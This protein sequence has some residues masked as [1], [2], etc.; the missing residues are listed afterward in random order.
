MITEIFKVWTSIPFSL[1]EDTVKAICDKVSADY[2]GL[3]ISICPDMDGLSYWVNL[4]S[5]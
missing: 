2:T 3:K 1:S 5:Y 4:I